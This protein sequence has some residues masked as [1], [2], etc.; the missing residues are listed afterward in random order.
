LLCEDLIK[1]GYFGL[2]KPNKKLLDRAGNYIL[3][4][5]DNYSIQDVIIGDDRRQNKA[6]H[7]GVSKEEMFVPLIVTTS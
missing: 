3:L 5:K 2:F 6:C 7:G 4:M 1:K